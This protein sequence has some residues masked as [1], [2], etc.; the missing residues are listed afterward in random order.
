VI[1]V[2]TSTGRILHREPLGCHGWYPGQVVAGNGM[3]F[4]TCQRRQETGL[5][6]GIRAFDVRESA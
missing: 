6:S 5:V 1:V 2:E 4:A 3:L